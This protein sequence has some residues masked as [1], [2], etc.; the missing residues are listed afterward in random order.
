MS[1]GTAWCIFDKTGERYNYGTLNFRTPESTLGATKWIELGR[2][3][4]PNFVFIPLVL[5]DPLS[6]QV[7]SSPAFPHNFQ[8]DGKRK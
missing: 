2:S 3:V 7:F 6:Y 1:Q 8:E 4:A 5:H